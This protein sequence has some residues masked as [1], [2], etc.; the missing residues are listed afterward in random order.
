MKTSLGSNESTCITDISNSNEALQKAIIEA[1]QNRKGKDITIVDMQHIE[2]APVS[3]FIIAQGTSTMN[4]SAIADNV[5]EE[6]LGNYHIKPYN[7]DG[8]E[9]SKWIVLDYGSILVHIF[10]PDE[11]QRYALEELWADAHVN[12]ISNID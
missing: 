10:V 3:T 6:L 9:S 12:E 8:Y 7:Y 11:R 2:D 1:I 4:V 5:R